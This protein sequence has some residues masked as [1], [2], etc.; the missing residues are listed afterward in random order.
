MQGR[1][2]CPT[3]GVL[4]RFESLGVTPE[5]CPELAVIELVNDRGWALSHGL[6]P[7]DARFF[8]SLPELERFLSERPAAEDWQ[9]K[10]ALGTAGRGQRS[11]RA[12]QLTEADRKWLAASWAMGGVLLEPRREIFAEYSLHGWLGTDGS[13]RRGRVV[14]FDTHSRAFASAR[15]LLPGECLDGE[16]EALGGNLERTAAAL[17]GAGYFGPFGL[18]AYAWSLGPDV[19][20]FEALSEVN[21]RYT[22]A[23]ALGMSD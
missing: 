13:L 21:A 12:Q 8:E 1:A 18:D 6:A 23:Y 15:P 9:A 7:P 10:R 3:P 4:A 16:I 19:R 11:L 20:C 5:P 17:H 2:F 14:A 22:L